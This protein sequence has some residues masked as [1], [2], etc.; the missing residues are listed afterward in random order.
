MRI[1]RHFPKRIYYNVSLDSLKHYADGGTANFITTR[2]FGHAWYVFKRNPKHG[3]IDKFD[4]TKHR[5]RGGR[6]CI[7]YWDKGRIIKQVQRQQ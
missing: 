3:Q 6:G 4:L 1:T 2:S 7:F 5:D